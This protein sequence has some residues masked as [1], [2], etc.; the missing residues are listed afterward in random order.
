MTDGSDC[1]VEARAPSSGSWVDSP[2]ALG[3]LRAVHARGRGSPAD[4]A[5]L[6]CT[7]RSFRD[8]AQVHWAE[9]GRFRVPPGKPVH[10]S[11]PLVHPV[12]QPGERGHL[13]AGTLAGDDATVAVVDLRTGRWSSTLVGHDG[14]VLD[15]AWSPDGS[16]LATACYDG[17]VRVWDP[18]TGRRLAHLAKFHTGWVLAL[19]WSCDG[20]WVAASSEDGWVRVWD[21]G[22]SQSSSTSVLR[23]EY[24]RERLGG[25][26]V[27]S[28][29]WSP[30]D[31]RVLAL[32]DSGGNVI[33]VDVGEEG[34]GDDG[35][36]GGRV[37]VMD[38]GHEGSEVQSLVWQ[39]DG[40]GLATAAWDGTVK[41]WGLVPSEEGTPGDTV[42]RRRIDVGDGMGHRVALSADGALVAV[43]RFK[44]G[45]IVTWFEED[46]NL[47][48][49]C[50]YAVATGRQVSA[51][52]DPTRQCDVELVAWEA[53]GGG[54]GGGQAGAATLL[55]LDTPGSEEPGV[56]GQ[57]AV[58]A[59]DILA[60][61]A[62]EAITR[63]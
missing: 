37:R 15:L 28:M 31:S 10:V 62:P 24:G 2:A 22:R 60:L 32:G 54:R 13:V 35:E 21:A 58:L 47:R 42:R 61:A 45:D 39:E 33:L 17:I 3:V 23:Q 63:E 7:C 27:L 38:E 57:R 18:A 36:G 4:V 16:K 44:V 30:V 43:E 41:V 52:D 1:D 53:V 12:V 8:L 25:G 19:A 6:C 51:L 9:L 46:R 40:K 20:R 50:V 14:S 34:D 56:A 59:V 5:R 49:V 11:A 29:G 55:V 26:K 48:W